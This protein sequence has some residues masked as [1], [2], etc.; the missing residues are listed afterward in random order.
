MKKQVF[1]IALTVLAMPI[2]LS[3]RFGGGGGAPA[4]YIAPTT[5]PTTTPALSTPTPQQTPGGT[6]NTATSLADA[7]QAAGDQAKA[8]VVGGANSVATTGLPAANPNSAW[9]AAGIQYAQSGQATVPVNASTAPSKALG[10]LGGK[11]KVNLGN[12]K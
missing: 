10:R 7:A 4:R 3:A 12:A 1:I 5:T 2:V 9:Y 8:D 6:Y 11:A